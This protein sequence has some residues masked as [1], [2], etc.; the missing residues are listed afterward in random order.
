MW[1]LGFSPISVKN[2]TDVLMGSELLCRPL[3]ETDI[4]T[5]LDLLITAQETL[6]CSTVFNSVSACT[7]DCGGS[8]SPL[9]GVLLCLFLRLQTLLFHLLSSSAPRLQNGPVLVFAESLVL[10][11]VFWFYQLACLCYVAF[12][13]LLKT[14]DALNRW[15]SWWGACY[16][17]MIIWVWILVPIKSWVQQCTYITPELWVVGRDRQINGAHWPT[18]RPAS[19]PSQADELQVQWETLPQEMR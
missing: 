17:S 5:L 12:P 11:V 4:L 3:S 8:S 10:V 6:P 16:V 7:V 13:G 14:C 2:I 1:I 19:Q 9:L 18:Y 15:L